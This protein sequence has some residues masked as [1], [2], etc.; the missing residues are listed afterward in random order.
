MK[1]NRSDLSK[2]V[3]S[4]KR[5]FMWYAAS[6][7]L[8]LILVSEFPKS[9]G[10]WYC[11]MLSDY[12]QLPY[13]RNKM[14][15]LQKSILHGH[16]Y[17]HNNFNKT[18][19]VIRDGR[20]VMVSYYHHL[21]TGNNV[22]QQSVV[23]KNRAAAPFENFEN[24]WDN[25][26]QFIEYMF[27]RYTMAGKKFTWNGLINTYLNKDRVVLVRYESL[28]QDAAGTL[29][30]SVQQLLNK[31][32]DPVKLEQVVQKFSFQ[33][34][35]SRKPGEEDKKS[36]LRKGIAGDWKNNFSKEASEVFDFYAGTDLIKLG[37]EKDRNWY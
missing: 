4:L 23:N 9:G 15:K 24:I 21:Y 5:R 34:I 11:Q 30:E 37:Y 36:F 2:K 3:A 22:L 10:T 8:D 19:C 25:M 14:P 26:P 6:G 12:L 35:T 32:P 7:A 31:S 17:H 1:D 13:P 33:N 20:D 16:F 18:V 29:G 28:L 27:T